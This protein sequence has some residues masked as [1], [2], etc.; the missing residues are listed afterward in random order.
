[1]STFLKP[2]VIVST[3]LGLLVRELSLPSLVWRDPVGDFAGAFNDTISIRLPAF[4]SG[5]SR[6]LRSGA[7]RTQD[8]LFE[9]KVDLT[10]DTDVYLDVP[11][12]DEQLTLDIRNFGEQVLNPMVEG[13]GRTIEDKLVAVI[14][15]AT[16]QSTIA[17]NSATQTPYKDVAVPARRLLNQARVPMGGRAI[18]CGSELEAA[19]LVDDQFI[20]ADHIGASAE[21]TVREGLIGRIAG[22]SVYSSPALASAEGYAFHQTAYALSTRAPVVPAGAPY[23]ASLAYAGMA[24]RSVRIFDPDAVQD[25][26][27]LD[28]WMGASAVKDTGHFDADPTA[29]GRFVPVTDPANPLAGQASAWQDDTDRLVRAVKITVS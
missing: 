22:F 1:M 20:R 6:T 24:L 21:Q 18:I 19:I 11:I 8:A 12:T 5:R 29:G 25:R 14:E 16:Y 27:L 7:A 15:A 10:L 26:L 13:I 17:F 9:R 3:A 2:T 23:G 28:A 4:V